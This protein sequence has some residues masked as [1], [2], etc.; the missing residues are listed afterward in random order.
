M[1]NLVQ[2]ELA[3]Y[4]PASNLAFNERIKRLREAG[5]NIYHFAFGQSPFPVPSELQEALKENTY[6]SAYLPVAGN[7][8]LRIEIARL[9]S[10][11]DG[12]KVDSENI[13]V[14]PGSK[15]LIFL[16]FRIFNGKILCIS[17]TWTTYRPQAHLAGRD[18]FIIN[19]NYENQWKITPDMV[20]KTLV[21][22]NID[23]MK[24]NKLLVLCNPDNPTGAT[25]NET[26]LKA[27]TETFKENNILV[28]TDEIYGR[29]HYQQKHCT[30]ANFY[31][32]GTIL[33]S[34]FSKWSSAGGWRVGYHIYPEKLNEL[35]NGVKSAASHT[36]SCA[37][38]PMQYALTEYLR[39][40]TAVD[41]YI[42]HCSRV[43]A[44]VEKYCRE[45]LCDV[46]VRVVPSGGGFYMMPDFE[47]VR[48]SLSRR[49]IHTGQQMCDAMLDECN[50]AL[51]SGGPAFLRPNNEL[52]VRFCYVNFDGT[53]PLEKSREIGLDNP[54]PKGFMEEYIP[55]MCNGIKVG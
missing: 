15:E 32:E 14:G 13:L 9:H 34:G 33:S 22:A 8:E 27:L 50:V 16:L 39:N 4:C 18:S 41:S 35:R 55:D 20:K 44:C 52:T 10:R 7:E 45:A 43:L 54:L 47:V 31:P 40:E 30:L 26:E 48:E 5:N 37:P 28:L 24:E 36:F 46:G 38:A 1:A 23:G 21:E 53:K 49:N 6:R 12:L 29:L 3:N 2:P 17:P 51:M 25:Y 19:T 11:Y 42:K